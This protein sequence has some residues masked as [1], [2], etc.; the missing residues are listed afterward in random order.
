[1]AMNKNVV[2]FPTT[3]ETD[4]TK[5]TIRNLL[6]IYF[7]DHLHR[8]IGIDRMFGVNGAFWTS[9]GWLINAM[10]NHR[11]YNG[12][13]RVILRNQIL[14]RSRD[15]KAI[16]SFA[17]YLY[18]FM[19]ENT[20]R[21]VVLSIT[22]FIEGTD[23][24][25]VNDDM[26]TYMKERHPNY[27]FIHN[28]EKITRLVR[29]IAT[30]YN[31]S[32]PDFE[33]QYALFCD[34][35]TTKPLNHT[36][37]I[38]VNPYDFYT[39][40]FGDRWSTCY[41]IDVHG[42]RKETRNLGYIGC[43]CNG[44]QSHMLDAASIVVYTIDNK[45][46]ECPDQAPKNRMCFFF[47]GED[48]IIQSRVYPDARDFRGESEVAAQLRHIVQ[49]AISEMFNLPNYW[50]VV[51]GSS[52]CTSSIER[53]GD[54]VEYADWKYFDDCNVSYLRLANGNKNK[55]K[56]I[57]GAKTICPECG[58]YHA[59]HGTLFCEECDEDWWDDEDWDEDE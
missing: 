1:M 44:T 43:N 10:K 33:R 29:R 57:V 18:T 17:S 7:A 19:P 37:V 54:D 59:S 49:M 46:A 3:K 27:P 25:Y 41:T 28:G 11:S 24:S 47:I 13:L 38:S 31:F 6:N 56:I 40:S 53:F 8:E 32:E 45:Y 39:C 51:R 35:M 5:E 52:V 36:V 14:K 30:D 16:S 34:A 50:T 55:N 4:S 15:N 9:K 26:Y 2:Y 42:I 22:R 48:K 23:L 20:G 21:D 58:E 12:D